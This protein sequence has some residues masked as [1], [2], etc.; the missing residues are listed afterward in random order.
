MS[1]NK[2][3]NLINDNKRKSYE[4]LYAEIQNTQSKLCRKKHKKYDIAEFSRYLESKSV[5]EGSL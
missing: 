3:K 2:M 1:Y 4:P 5:K